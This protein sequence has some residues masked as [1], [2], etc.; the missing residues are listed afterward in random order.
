MAENLGP[1]TSPREAD[2]DQP[3]VL[4]VDDVADLRSLMRIAVERDGRFQVVGEASNGLEAI[5]LAESLQP[6]VVLLDLAMPEMDGLQAIPLI[7]EHLGDARIVVLS[8]FES[9]RVARQAIETCADAYIEKGVDSIKSI[10][11]FILR[12]LQAPPKSL[13]LAAG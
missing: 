1:I 11:D 3:R 7:R 4:L 8:G 9:S 12:V 10:P 13:G 5:R 2:L 6:D